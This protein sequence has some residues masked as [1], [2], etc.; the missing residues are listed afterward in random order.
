MASLTLTAPEPVVAP[1]TRERRRFLW[2]LPPLAA[3]GLLVFYPLG[4]VGWTALTGESDLYGAGTGTVLGKVLTSADFTKALVNTIEIAGLSTLG[5]LV[6]GFALALIVAFVPFP[7]ARFVTRFID[8]MLAFPS[9]LIALSFTFVYGRAGFLNGVLDSVAGAQVNVLYSRWGVILAEITF[10]IPFVM[11]PLLAAFSQIDSSVIEVA[12]SLGARPWRVIRQVI[13]P[14]AVPAL[15]AGGS[16]CLVLTLNEFGIILFIGAKGVTT[17][18][19]LIYSQAIQLS[20]YTAACA[21]AVVNVVLSLG[22][23]ALYRFLINQAGGGGRA[24][25]E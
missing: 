17:L 24:A 2:M 3:L 23:Y 7:G 6:L 22:L 25:V 21:V 19:L 13:F 1:A 12:G 16:L 15:L 14:E 9:F 10:Y 11:R 20:D 8:I 5:C 4:Y 18:P